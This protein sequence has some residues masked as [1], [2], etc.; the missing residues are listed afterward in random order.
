MSA[1]SAR[2]QKNTSGV[3]GV[4]VAVPAPSSSVPLNS[5]AAGT[6]APGRTALA[7][8]A[9]STDPA[10]A[11][12]GPSRRWPSAPSPAIQ[13]PARIHSATIGGWSR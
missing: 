3:S 9:S 7:A 13:V 11:D 5:A 1:H 4:I 6:P 12:S 8:C 10:A 2:V